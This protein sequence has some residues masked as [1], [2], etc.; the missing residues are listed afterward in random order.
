MFL[1]MRL[2]NV[3]ALTLGRWRIMPASDV[4]KATATK[5]GGYVCNFDEVV[6]D[7]H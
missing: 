7:D 5:R 2:R 1:E 3:N 6:I 4:L